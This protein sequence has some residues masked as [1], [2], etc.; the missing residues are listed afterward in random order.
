[1]DFP[2]KTLCL[3]LA[4]FNSFPSQVSL[5]ETPTKLLVVNGW[6]SNQKVPNPQVLNVANPAESCELPQFP[7]DLIWS[8]GGY[9]DE[10]AVICSGR[11]P[12]TWLE[13]NTCY[14][15]DNSNGKFVQTSSELTFP[16]ALAG[17]VVTSDEKL[18][19]LGGYSPSGQPMMVTEM[20]G[21]IQSLRQTTND[22]PSSL[23]G[24]CVAKINQ[25]T[26]IG[27]SKL[28]FSNIMFL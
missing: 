20:Y 13:S 6:S 27:T 5:I 22:L 18:W 7:Q 16:R 9:T 15:L 26:A 24:F 2:T 12:H 14:L 23:F 17:S 8:T 10:G 11:H 28:I 21:S 3:I 19:V 1:M 4:I 25:T